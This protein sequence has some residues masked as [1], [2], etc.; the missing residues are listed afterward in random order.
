M[1]EFLGIVI[2]LVIRIIRISETAELL[3][4][5]GITLSDEE[6]QMIAACKETEKIIRKT[7]DFYNTNHSEIQKFKENHKE[8]YTILQKDKPKI[9]VTVQDLA[10]SLKT[11][12]VLL[13][14][15]KRNYS[16]VLN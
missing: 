10:T 4:K 16:L 13:L 8:A 12:G 14:P 7:I 2:Q 1:L 3:Q 15:K 11:Q 6:L 9:E 5:S